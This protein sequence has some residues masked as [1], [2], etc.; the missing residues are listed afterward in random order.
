MDRNKFDAILEKVM[1]VRGVKINRENFLNKELSKYFSGELLL[2]RVEPNE[3]L[4]SWFAELSKKVND[5]DYE[6]STLAG[7][8]IQQLITA[9]T[10]VEEFEEFAVFFSLSFV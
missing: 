3:N 1:K 10:E 8:K 4:K 6:N 2:T 5:L 7:R 9:L